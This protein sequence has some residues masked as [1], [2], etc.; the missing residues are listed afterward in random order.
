MDL[1]THMITLY[2]CIYL[3]IGPMSPFLYHQ[4]LSDTTGFILI[5]Y[6]FHIYKYLA[7]IFL[8]V[9][10]YLIKPSLYNQSP[11]TTDLN[12]TQCCCENF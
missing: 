1:H 12:S 5:F 10:T 7:P 9:F 4:F 8:N 3:Y 6:P 2:F 11:I